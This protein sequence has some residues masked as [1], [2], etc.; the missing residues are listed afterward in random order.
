[1][2]LTPLDA[3]VAAALGGSYWILDKFLGPSAT[4]IGEQ[5]KVYG[6]SRWNAILGV[7]EK[8]AVSKQVVDKIGPIPPGLLFRFAANASFSEDDPTITEWWASLI[9]DA[10][11]A[12]TNK[13]AIFADMMAMIGPKEAACFRTFMDGFNL[14]R[15][16]EL[17]R[18]LDN[19]AAG[20]ETTFAQAARHW[21][22]NFPITQVT[23]FEVRNNMLRGQIPWPLRPI[24]WQYPL[25]WETGEVHSSNML[26]PDH[27][28]NLIEFEVLER[29]GILRRLSTIVENNGHSASVTA[30]ATTPLGMDFYGT[31]MGIQR[32]T[33]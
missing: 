23:T 18:S 25:L 8:Q 33:E 17:Y 9:L 31:C 11:L 16:G 1:M 6:Q 28:E 12:G 7:A 21:F 30:L 10:A 14:T 22:G 2:S 19:L 29:I 4:A 27:R 13:H 5:I 32:S 3:G 15:T 26:N 24:S 20:L